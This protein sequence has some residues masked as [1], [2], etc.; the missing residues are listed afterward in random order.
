[1]YERRFSKWSAWTSR[2]EMSGLDYPGIYAIARSS[3]DIHDQRFRWSPEIVYV[4][5]TNSTSGLRGRL[6]QFDATISGTLRHGG[7]DRVR[8]KHRNYRRLSSELYVSVAPFRCDVTSGLAKDLRIMGDVARFE[9]HCLAHFTDR[10]GRL[11]EFND[12]STSKYSL[13]VGRK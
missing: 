8:F 9:Y 11:P 4:G 10:F 6:R 3:R 1:V 2:G 13:T 5:M 7:A 12:K